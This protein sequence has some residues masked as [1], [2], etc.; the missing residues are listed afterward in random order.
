[1]GARS[2]KLNCSGRR[3][4]EEPYHPKTDD[5]IIENGK[6]TKDQNRPHRNVKIS[7]KENVPKKVHQ[8]TEKSSEASS[9]IKPKPYDFAK[10]VRVNN[11]DKTSPKSHINSPD[12][13]S[14]KSVI[15][16][17]DADHNK[18]KLKEKGHSSIPPLNNDSSLDVDCIPSLNSEQRRLSLD[19]N[20]EWTTEY[21]END[22]NAKQPQNGKTKSVKEETKSIPIQN[23]ESDSPTD[24]ESSDDD[25]DYVK[26]GLSFGHVG[27]L[28]IGTG[29]IIDRSTKIVPR[30]EPKAKTKK[31]SSTKGILDNKKK[32]R[33]GGVNAKRVDNLG[34]GTV[35][36]LDE[37]TI[38]PEKVPEKP[39][40]VPVSSKPVEEKKQ[41]I[42]VEDLEK[43]MGLKSAVGMIYGYQQTGTAFRVGVDKIITAWHVVR[44][45]RA[46]GELGDHAVF[47]D[48]NYEKD[49]Q[50]D[51][52]LRFPL[53][54]DVL[55][56]NEKLDIAVLQIKENLYGTTFPKPLE[57]F[58]NFT[59]Q[60]HEKYSI[61]LIGHTGAGKKSVDHVLKYWDPLSH[62]IKE[63][64]EW[65][66]EEF[67]LKHGF[68]YTGIGDET[69]LHFQCMFRHGA[70]G[71]PGFIVPP[72]GEARVVTVL[73]R[74]FPDFYYFDNFTDEE[75]ERVP[76]EKLIQQGSNI[77]AIKKDMQTKNMDLY[78]EIF[79]YREFISHSEKKKCIDTPSE[80]KVLNFP[81]NNEPINT[82]PV[83]SKDAVTLSPNACSEQNSRNSE[84]MAILASG[85]NKT[86]PITNNF[87]PTQD[88]N[89]GDE[90]KSTTNAAQPQ[91][92]PA[93]GH[94]T[95]DEKSQDQEKCSNNEESKAGT[96]CN[97]AETTHAILSSETAPN[98][99]VKNQDKNEMSEREKKV[100]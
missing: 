64:Y 38:Q 1:M 53:K 6:G 17:P 65:C 21:G 7:S 91:T 67:V 22:E 95:E 94:Q 76:T 41:P 55:Y 47:V 8:T 2:S 61:Y 12:E 66:E 63:L 32:S 86:H 96:T 36:I 31:K 50:P 84:N 97:N 78:R 52:L 34:I 89:S 59:R 49:F 19:A 46:V 71:C 15:S 56:H 85:G 16:S 14:P 39:V 4:K 42:P 20:I 29:K 40:N 58:V 28:V 54:P 24:S 83:D 13:T 77:D 45:I 98:S 75:R 87:D 70:S 25:D 37:R 80:E 92:P 43:L 69:R 11:F 100:W 5:R 3:P 68:G 10:S 60:I 88:I 33:K 23:D 81:Q 48:F 18:T 99:T 93:I 74:G 51:H 82:E 62:R 30:K 57:N 26:G 73:L 72:G 35:M 79:H 27:N 9:G 90:E 44:A